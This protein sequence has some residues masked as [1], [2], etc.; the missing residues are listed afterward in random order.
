MTSGLRLDLGRTALTGAPVDRSED[1]RQPDRVAAAWPTARVL[2]IAPGGGLTTVTRSGG[3]HLAFE[4]ATDWGA[5]P[6]P[7][8]V[9]LGSFG[10]T[11]YW[12]L[13]DDA[14]GPG[15]LVRVIGPLLP[16]DEAELATTA[17]ALVG[18]HRSAGFCSRCGSATVPDL[19]GH[20]R[21]CA[22][23]HQEFPR[24]DPAVIVLIHDGLDHIVLGRQPSWAPG[25]FSV[26]AGFAEAGESLEATVAREM[27]E[28]VG[29]AVDDVTYLG[30][31][32][33]PFPRSLMIAFSARAARGAPLTP[34]AGEI[35]DARWFSRLELAGLLAAS[36]G[37]PADPSRITLPG[38][39]SI[40]RRMVES[41]VH[42]R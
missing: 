19:T 4:A 26:L 40:A 1:L 22:A 27:R 24:L 17:V 31:Q 30:S 16:D 29:L 25:R 7:T 38:P 8:S 21:V 34:R 37:G 36:D 6:P 12:A 23:G 35:D 15:A 20:S 18:W 10:G 33:W 41:F 14:A 39:V 32:P 28:E 9:L 5:G 42:A 13:P 3:I 2:R 11:D